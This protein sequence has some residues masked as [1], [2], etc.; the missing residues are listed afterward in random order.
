MSVLGTSERGFEMT[1]V[2]S[3]G[4]QSL[5]TRRGFVSPSQCVMDGKRDAGFYFSDLD[6]LQVVETPSF[7]DGERTVRVL[8]RL[9]DLA[10]AISLGCG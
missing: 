1:D 8:F 5:V 3:S 10:R 6:S 9:V 7:P 2:R 4:D